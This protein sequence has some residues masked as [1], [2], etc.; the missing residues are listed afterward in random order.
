MRDP[1]WV[2]QQYGLCRKRYLIGHDQRVLG[3]IES[4]GYDFWYARDTRGLPYVYLGQW[5]T[6][7]A[8]KKAVEN[9]TVIHRAEEASNG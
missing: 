6:E 7:D 9:A 3:E 8:A 1:V 4:D 5:A 2:V